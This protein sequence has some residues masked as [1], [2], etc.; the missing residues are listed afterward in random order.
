MQQLALALVSA[1]VSLREAARRL[2]PARRTLSRWLAR[3]RA[4]FARHA[5]ALRA[6]LPALGRTADFA[7]FWR[8]CLARLP[9]SEAMVQVLR[10]G[11]AVP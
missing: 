1:G 11:V 6:Q 5:F 8:A 2:K 9:L 4:C 7:D 10:T 3:F